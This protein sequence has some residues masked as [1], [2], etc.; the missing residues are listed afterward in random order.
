MLA[1]S[2][3]LT[4]DFESPATLR[5]CYHSASS[6]EERFLAVTK[7]SFFKPLR[8]KNLCRQASRSS[9]SCR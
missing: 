1:Y 4:L 5:S 6:L 3:D 2:T 8:T 7:Y 9:F